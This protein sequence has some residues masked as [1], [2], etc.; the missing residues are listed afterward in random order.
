MNIVNV[1]PA[2]PPG[3]LG[4]VICVYYILEINREYTCM[5]VI[6]TTS[7]IKNPFNWARFSTANVLVSV[8]NSKRSAR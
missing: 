3:L 1:P 5:A 7:A 4:D 6:G 8:C 2:I